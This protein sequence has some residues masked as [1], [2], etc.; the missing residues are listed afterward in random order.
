MGAA[1]AVAL[2]AGCESGSAPALS[3]AGL[4]KTADAIPSEGQDTCPLAYDI[5]KAAKAAGA[6]GASAP[7]SVKEPGEAVAT[8]EGGKR[9]EADTPLAQNPGALVSCVFHIGQE[10][11]VVHTAATRR[12]QAVAPL[13]PIVGQLAGS[14]TKDLIAYINRM[15]KAKTGEPVVTESGNVVSVRLKL[16]GEGD[17]VMVVGAGDARHPALDRERIAALATSLADQVA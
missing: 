9:A 14:S 2:L 5:T 11:V 16:D 13:A 4:T 12:P 7:G 3:L 15:A 10:E 1:A 17:A 8:A 6:E